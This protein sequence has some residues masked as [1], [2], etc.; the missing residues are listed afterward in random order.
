MLPHVANG[1]QHV[2]EE[3]RRCCQIAPPKGAMA[4]W[5]HPSRC[6]MFLSSKKDK[7]LRQLEQKIL[8]LEPSDPAWQRAA[9]EYVKLQNEQLKAGEYA[10]KVSDSSSPAEYVH[11]PAP[12]EK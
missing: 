5:Q 4:T 11:P 10:G 12:W 3:L 8:D 9:A 2:P 7:G 6:N 1:R